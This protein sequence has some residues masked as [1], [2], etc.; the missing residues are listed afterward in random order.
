MKR[1][2]YILFLYSGSVH[3][4]ENFAEMFATLFMIDSLTLLLKQ[5]EKI[6]F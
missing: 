1:K 6:F 2:I 4:F 5:N 3:N